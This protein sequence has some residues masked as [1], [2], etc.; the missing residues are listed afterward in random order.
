MPSNIRISHHTRLEVCTYAPGRPE[1]FTTIEA[2]LGFHFDDGPMVELDEGGAF[3][4][5]GCTRYREINTTAGTDSFRVW[6]FGETEG[7]HID[8]WPDWLPPLSD[9]W[10]AEAVEYAEHLRERVAA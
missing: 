7:R 8:A 4:A 9:G 1:E 2:S 6:I 5:T 10:D 3:Q